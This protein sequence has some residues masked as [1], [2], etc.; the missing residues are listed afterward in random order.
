MFYFFLT[1]IS[2]NLLIQ[3]F[4]L[5]S[6]VETIKTV[7]DTNHPMD[8]YPIVLAR[9]ETYQKWIKMF[10]L[11]EHGDLPNM[12]GIIPREKQ[13]LKSVTLN[14]FRCLRGL[15][16]E[17]I[18]GLLDLILDGKV[19]LRKKKELGIDF[20]SMED[21]CKDIKEIA[22][23]KTGITDYFTTKYKEINDYDEIAKKYKIS[24]KEVHQYIAWSAEFIKAYLKPAKSTPELPE[25][26]TSQLEMKRKMT[27]GLQMASERAYEIIEVTGGLHNIMSI[28]N[29]DYVY[30]FSLVIC[31]ANSR[32]IGV[33]WSQDVFSK[34]IHYTNAVCSSNYYTM[35]FFVQHGKQQTDCENALGSIIGVSKII[36]AQ[37][38]FSEETP[39]LDGIRLKNPSIL[40]ILALINKNPNDNDFS[41]HYS[42]QEID[43]LFGDV[44]DKS[45]KLFRAPEFRHVGM[46]GGLIVPNP[47]THVSIERLIKYFSRRGTY[48]LDVCT[49]GVVLRA[50]LHARRKAICIALN[51]NEFNF[52][53]KFIQDLR[54]GSRI[55]GDW[56]AKN[57]AYNTQEGQTIETDTGDISGVGDVVVVEPISRVGDALVDSLVDSLVDLQK[58]DS[59]P[60]PHPP[61]PTPLPLPSPQQQ[62]SAN[63]LESNTI[64]GTYFQVSSLNYKL[65]F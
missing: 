38:L 11:Y 13:D 59:I 5:Q 7:F 57:E 43:L 36:Y 56:L 18:D 1:L 32:A 16:D 24:L 26:V 28:C 45:N 9:E 2:L 15:E 63:T 17:E 6:F 51:N 61:S 53:E 19:L 46:K 4:I 64:E 10:A 35:V 60:H 27:L 37:Y 47:K 31:D 44:Q 55:I 39:T 58:L 40:I 22:A 48:V 62:A 54:K 14:V 34:I 41:K 65:S 42:G 49:G 12:D 25:T 29:D 52:Y 3:C 20:K 50:A 21:F 33:E 23:M 8:T 30:E